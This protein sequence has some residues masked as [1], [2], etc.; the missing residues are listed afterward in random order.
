MEWS[1]VQSWRE[2]QGISRNCQYEG[3]TWQ[4]SSWNFR[5]RFNFGR[6][7]SSYVIE[8]WGIKTC[9]M[10]FVFICWN[11][12]CQIFSCIYGWLVIL[13]FKNL[14][15]H[16]QI[17]SHSRHNTSP[18]CRLHRYWNL[19]IPPNLVIKWKPKVIKARVKVE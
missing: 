13:M 15:A 14:H 9:K 18:T 1:W 8:R 16:A 10:I 5:W 2:I 6:P 12:F 3:Q 7:S 17:F 19:I 4:S 11:I